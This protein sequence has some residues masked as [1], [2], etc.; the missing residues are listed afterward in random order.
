[1]SSAAD[2]GGSLPDDLREV[3]PV[4]EVAHV[5]VGLAIETVEVVDFAVVEQVRDN[6]RDVAGLDTGS[7]VLTVATA[8]DVHAVSVD[9]SL[10][11]SSGGAGKVIVP[12]QGRSR[13][14]G[15]VN[16]VVSNDA[17]LVGGGLA[18]SGRSGL[19][20]LL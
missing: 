14:V 17:L 10:S 8:V 16:I 15:A 5:G 3:T 2:L 1:M 4:L 18:S 20:C 11:N 6:G 13:V 7:N 12:S 9:T 19:G